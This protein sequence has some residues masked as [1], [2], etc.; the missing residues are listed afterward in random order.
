[1]LGYRGLSAARKPSHLFQIVTEEMEYRSTSSR[2]DT[3]DEFSRHSVTA[4]Q[5]S[6]NAVYFA[7]YCARRIADNR[8]LEAGTS[9]VSANGLEQSPQSYS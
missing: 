6:L 2:R 7:G 8:P 9:R 4:H 1:M 3:Y 5:P